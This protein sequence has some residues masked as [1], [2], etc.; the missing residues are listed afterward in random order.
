MGRFI[1]LLFVVVAVAVAVAVV[2]CGD[3]IPTDP[4]EREEMAQGCVLEHIKRQ[5]Y[6]E[7][8]ASATFDRWRAYQ[9]QYNPNVYEVQVFIAD[10]DGW[11]RTRIFDVEL[12]GNTRC[13]V[14]LRGQW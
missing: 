3:G 2:G 10:W 4:Q 13:Y 11:K 6:L 8:P 1:K 9:D 5:G 14:A 7:A 12:T